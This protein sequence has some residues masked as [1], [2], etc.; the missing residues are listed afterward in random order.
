MEQ[1]AAV[2]YLVGIL[3]ECIFSS[4]ILAKL[5]GCLYYF[6]YQVIFLVGDFIRSD[7]CYALVK[8]TLKSCPE[9]VVFT[10]SR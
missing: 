4:D 8:S 2:V 1:Y 10:K 6:N 7:R 3:L 9:D 5:L